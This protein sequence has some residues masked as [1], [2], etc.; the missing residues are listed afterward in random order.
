MNRL[1]IVLAVLP[2]LIVA[3][4]AGAES[5]TKSRD[6]ILLNSS[7]LPRKPQVYQT[8]FRNCLDTLELSNVQDAFILKSGAIAVLPRRDTVSATAGTL[9]QFCEHFPHGTLHFIATRDR[10]QVKAISRA[11]SMSSAN[12][13]SCEKIKGG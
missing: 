1:A 8:L 6:H 9:R 3:G 13:T 12:A 11:V 10:A 2:G 7:D 4:E 5:C